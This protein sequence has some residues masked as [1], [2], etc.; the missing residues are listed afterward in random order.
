MEQKVDPSNVIHG[1][2]SDFYVQINE[3][4]IEACVILS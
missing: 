2:H 4:E 1:Q 3:A